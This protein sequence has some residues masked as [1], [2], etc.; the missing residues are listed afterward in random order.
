MDI[1]AMET[2]YYL[3]GAGGRLATGQGQALMDR[4]FNVIG[5]ETRDEFRKLGF[6]DQLQIIRA[7]LQS[8]FRHEQARVV[9][10]FVHIKSGLVFLL[11]PK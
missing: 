11:I 2:V 4:G 6:A 10:K 7:D 3:P 5:R 9:R 8:H 1:T